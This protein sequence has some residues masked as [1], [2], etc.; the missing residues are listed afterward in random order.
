MFQWFS[1]NWGGVQTN[2]HLVQL[3]K[4]RAP[5]LARSVRSGTPRLHASMGICVGLETLRMIGR[6]FSIFP[7]PI[8]PSASL[9]RARQVFRFP[10]PHR[11]ANK[12]I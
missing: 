7:Y 4:P 8:S 11:E 10:A 12:A 2:N 6:A 1:A 9:P 5:F 3:Q